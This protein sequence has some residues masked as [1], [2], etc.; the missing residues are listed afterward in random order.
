MPSFLILSIS[1]HNFGRAM[2][3]ELSMEE[4]GERALDAPQMDGGS[5]ST[6]R[7]WVQRTSCRL[8]F[9]AEPRGLF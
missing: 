4:S 5:G 1:S 3:K 6:Q 2:W 7:L 8:T 9:T